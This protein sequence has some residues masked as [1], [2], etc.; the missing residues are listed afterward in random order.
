M[1]RESQF[2]ITELPE[3]T[4]IYAFGSS[5]YSNAFSDVDLLFVIS[6][7]VDKLFSYDCV[8][9]FCRKLEANIG[10]AVDFTIL[11][12]LEEQKIRFVEQVKALPLTIDP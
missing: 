4:L 11:T 8:Q 5:T 9:K 6:D 12:D 3:G 1:K 7:S 2:F 10:T